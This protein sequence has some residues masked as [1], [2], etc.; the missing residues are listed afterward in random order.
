MPVL[1]VGPKKRVSFLLSSF[2]KYSKNWLRIVA[3]TCHHRT[4]AV[5]TEKLQIRGQT[6][7]Q[8]NDP[9]NSFLSLSHYFILSFFHLFADFKKLLL[10]PFMAPQ[11]QKFSSYCWRH[12][13][14]QKHSPVAPEMEL[15]W[16]TPWVLALR[17][18]EVIMHA[19]KGGRQPTA[20]HSYDV[21]EKQP[22]Q[23]RMAALRM[24]K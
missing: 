15:T 3:K 2:V 10:L 9:V 21:Y 18:P 12:L 24:E 22:W 5:E 19:C 13:E 4:K 6:G 14:L 17:V 8:K 11:M 7:L 1:L 16:L 20:L 23:H